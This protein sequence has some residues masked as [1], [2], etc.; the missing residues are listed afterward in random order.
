MKFIVL[1]IKFSLL[2][3]VSTANIIIIYLIDPELS[4]FKGNATIIGAFTF[5]FALND[6]FFGDL[7]NMILSFSQSVS[8]TYKNL[9][10]SDI[11][12]DRYLNDLSLL[13]K[14]GIFLRVFSGTAAAVLIGFSDINTETGQVICIIGHG[15]ISLSIVTMIQFWHSYEKAELKKRELILQEKELNARVNM[16]QAIGENPNC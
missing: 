3:L 9:L 13:W 10:L 7:R 2:V 14:I 16:H 4:N 8:I 11:D 15:T 6:K 12:I 1:I 5:V